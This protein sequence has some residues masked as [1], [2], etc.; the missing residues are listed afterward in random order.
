MRTILPTLLL[1]ITPAS[2]F[3]IDD[4]FFLR[5]N[6]YPRPEKAKISIIAKSKRL[7][8]GEPIIVK[9]RVANEGAFPFSCSTGGVRGDGRIGY[10]QFRVQFKQHLGIE[11]LRQ[12]PNHANTGGGM[13]VRSEERRVGK[14]C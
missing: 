12:H 3:A 2:A 11:G 6:S 14:E 13:V 8:L 10:R 4:G 5:Y 1:V 9:F 7:F